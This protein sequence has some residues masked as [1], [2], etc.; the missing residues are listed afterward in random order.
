MKKSK[1]GRP[2]D[3][4]EDW[5]GLHNRKLE[6]LRTIIGLIGTLISF[7]VFLRVFHFL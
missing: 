1:T 7:F 3:T 5:L 2:H 6:L 4:L